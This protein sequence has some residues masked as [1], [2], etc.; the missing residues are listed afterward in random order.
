MGDWRPSQ[1]LILASLSD[2]KP[3]SSRWIIK[4][5]GLSGPAV[6]NAL[7]RCWQGGLLLR[8]KESIYESK[9]VFKGRAGVGRVMRPYHLYVLRPEGV[10]S[11]RLDGHEFVKYH[12]KYLDVRGGGKRSKAQAI[13][14]FLKK[15]RDRAWFSK[16]IAGSLKD[17]GVKISDVM[18]NVRRFEKKGRVYVRG[19]KSEDRQ[20]PFREGY[21]ITWIDSDKPREQ[22]L[23]EAIERTNRALAERS[24]TSPLIER[25][26]RVRDVIFEHS[27]LRR[28]VSFSYIQNKLGCTDYEVEHAVSR[29]LQLY[30]DLKE[31]KL[32]KAYRY[33]FHTSITREDLNAAIAM[34]K[35]YIRIA[36]GRANRI[37]HNWEAIV[38]WFIDRFT[39]G[40]HFWSQEHRTKKMD[41]RRITLHLLKRVGGRRTA[42][43]VDRVWEVTPG[44]FVPPTTYVL[45]CKWGL[46]KKAHVDDFLEVL[47]WSK[48][49]GVNTPDGRKVKQGV[50]GVFAG[51]AFNPKESVQL[52]DGSKI[53]LSS[54]TAR[55][56]LQLLKA[57]DFNSKLRE[58]GCPSRVTV[59]KICKIAKDENEVRE[60]LD[61]IWDNSGRSEE[62]LKNVQAKNKKI[63]EFEKMLEETR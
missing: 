38:E 10:D 59:Q 13:L 61:A 35:N 52:K 54:Y 30:P 40:A 16:E 18:A 57:A 5:T 3:R 39:T 15:N 12:R 22:A 9:R 23:E 50:T 34:K 63:Y 49:F 4:Q 8:T 37:G 17:V 43:E 48:E 29:A 51:S 60:V 31:I 26:Y 47:R 45:S 46:V 44:V 33:Y 2:G 20:T 55:M 28:I 21:L 58:R 53:S 19:Y 32:F 7:K 42:A 25:V 27:K 1:R 36:K 56:N 11:L 14:D 24:S 62:I 6:W 41:P